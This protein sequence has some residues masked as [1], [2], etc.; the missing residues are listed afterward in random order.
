MDPGTWEWA[1]VEELPGNRDAVLELVI[2][3]DREQVTALAAIAMRDQANP[4]DLVRRYVV[5]RLACEQIA[6]PPLDQV[7]DTA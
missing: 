7:I 1:D 6:D 2:P 3:F 5:E 4:I